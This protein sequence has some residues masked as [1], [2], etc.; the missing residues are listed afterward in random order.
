VEF[1]PSRTRYRKKGTQRVPF[2]AKR[3]PYLFFAA[4]FFP[5]FAFFA[6]ED[7]SLH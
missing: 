1:D 6:I 4:F 7:A 2:L 5:P 3:R